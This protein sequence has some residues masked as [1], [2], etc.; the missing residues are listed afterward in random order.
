MSAQATNLARS[1]K[2]RARQRG[3]T[4][5]E[6]IMDHKVYQRDE[7]ICGIC[8]EDIDQED[9]TIDHIVPLI[10]GGQH[11]H[12]NVQATHRWCNAA[13]GNRLR[14]EMDFME[15]R[16]LRLGKDARRFLAIGMARE[17]MPFK[18]IARRLFCTSKWVSRQVVG[19]D[20]AVWERVRAA[21]ARITPGCP[22]LV[23]RVS[24]AP[25]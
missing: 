18:H 2:R 13:K 6:Y 14:I 1:K 25:R 10:R 17:G 23:A 4:Q 8:G 15:I 20:R 7:G 19:E 5:V 11:T 24:D 22:N 9:L 21:A 12:D 16:I 3:A